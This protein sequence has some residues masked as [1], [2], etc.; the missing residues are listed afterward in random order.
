MDGRELWHVEGRELCDTWTG[1]SCA[2]RGRE[3]AL[4]HVEGRELCDTWTGGSSGTRGR[5]GAMRHVEGRVGGIVFSTCPFVCE[6]VCYN[7][8][9]WKRVNRLRRTLVTLAYEL[10]RTRA[11]NGQRW[12]QEVKGRGHSRPRI[13]LEFSSH[14]PLGRVPCRMIGKCC[15]VVQNLSITRLAAIEMSVTIV[16]SE[17]ASPGYRW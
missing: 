10:Y 15:A 13:D 4:W 16:Y 8:I 3:G 7:V 9:F 6:F 11:W 12:A 17:W 5:E 2:T 1:G 14:W